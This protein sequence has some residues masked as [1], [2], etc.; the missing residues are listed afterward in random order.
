MVTIPDSE[1]MK[2]RIQ[3][4]IHGAVQG[5]GFRPFVYRLAN[6]FGLYGY[7]L[8]SSRG[9]FIEA[10]GPKSKLDRFLMALQDE[11]PVHAIIQSLE[12]S[13]LDA[14]GFSDFTI[15]KS[16]DD[17]EISAFIMP[18]IAVCKECL[19][20][21]FDTSDRR[22]LYPFINCTHCGPRFSLI[23]SL[24]YDRPNTS[25]KIFSMCDRCREEYQ[26][27][28]NRRFHAQPIACPDCGPQ[29]QLWDGAGE[30]LSDRHEALL[31]AVERI[32]RGET[33][34]L[35]GLGGFHLIA[36][37]TSRKAV[38]RLR[39]RKHREEKPFAVM[40]PSPEV[41]RELCEISEFEERL[42]TSP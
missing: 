26:D 40:V 32:R 23:E 6:R 9:V 14:G 41:A 37:A 4:I 31:Q 15:R 39:L 36:D 2:R 27:P 11:K 17:E 42:L 5:V 13:Y 38:E 30:V 21:M 12:F 19:R 16:R 8:N 20:E 25:M 34:A 10:E 28:L 1:K 29:L 18:D 3:I 35:K 7:V 33:V 24:P 22:Y